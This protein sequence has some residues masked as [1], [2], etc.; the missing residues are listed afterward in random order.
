MPVAVER[1][2]IGREVRSTDGGDERVWIVVDEDVATELDRVDPLGR[3][4]CRYTRDAG[5]VRLLLQ[6][7]RVGDDAA[8]L[9]G[10]RRH[11]EIAEGIDESDVR[12]DLRQPGT[13]PRMRGEDDGLADAAEAV[14]DPREPLRL[15]VGL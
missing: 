3:R 7:A 14:H 6:A 12:R 13:R 5:P 8:R 15:H 1:R 4:P 10:E 2:E 11:V 9:R